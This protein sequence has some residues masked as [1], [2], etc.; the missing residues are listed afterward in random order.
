ME[1]VEPWGY[2]EEAEHPLTGFLEME[3]RET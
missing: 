2:A 1:D 3:E